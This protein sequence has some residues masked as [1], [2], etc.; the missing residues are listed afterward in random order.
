MPSPKPVS[1]DSGTGS[2]GRTTPPQQGSPRNKLPAIEEDGVPEG[3]NE[4]QAPTGS[5]LEGKLPAVS[6]SCSYM[7]SSIRVANIL[8]GSFYRR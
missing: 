2:T 7:N 5:K 3:V 4:E 8:P 1:S 6:V